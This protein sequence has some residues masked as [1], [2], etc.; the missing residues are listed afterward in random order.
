MKLLA[1]TLIE[2]YY[3][4]LQY[5]NEADILHPNLEER[6]IKVIESVVCSSLY[7]LSLHYENVKNV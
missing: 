5:S 1:E 4:E 2:K 7:W 3:S 6:Y